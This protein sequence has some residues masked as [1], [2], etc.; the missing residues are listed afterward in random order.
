MSRLRVG[1]WVEVRS[2]EEI[3]KSLEKNGRLDELPFMPQMFQY[4]GQRYRVFKSAHKTCDTVNGSGGRWFSSGIH[5]DLRCDG[6][7]YGGCEAACLLFWK[8]K[9]LKGVDEGSGSVAT[10]LKTQGDVTNATLCTEEDVWRG[11]RGQDQQP[12]DETKYVCQ[13]TQLPY[14]TKHLPW[15]DARQYLQ[16]YKSGNA[17]LSRILCGVIY[18]SFY[19]GAQAWRNKIGYPARWVY[20]F[21]QSLWG[22]VPYPRKRGTIPAGQPTPACTLN[23]QPGEFVRVKSQ[24]EILSTVDANWMNRGLFFDAEL[25]PYCGGIYRVRARVCKFLDEKTGKMKTLKTPAIILEGVYCQ[26][27]YSNCRMFCPRSIYSWWREIWLERVSENI[28]KRLNQGS[29]SR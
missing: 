14:F 11:T 22:G 5:L 1:E 7:A 26:S 6:K 19:H 8:E 4:C 9:W 21:C 13:A 15:W 16:D 25:V 28:L 12:G 3:L 20:D 29:E 10:P 17:S 27:R 18:L 2:K 24:K 23:L